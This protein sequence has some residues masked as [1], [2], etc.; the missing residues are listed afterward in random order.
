MKFPLRLPFLFQFSSLCIISVMLLSCHATSTAYNGGS[1][2]FTCIFIHDT[3]TQGV[4]DDSG[5]NPF[6]TIIPSADSLATYSAIA[7][8]VSIDSVLPALCEKGFA[9]KSAYYDL[10]YRCMDAI[11]P[12]VVVVLMSPNS[13][14]LNQGFVFGNNGRFVCAMDLLHYSPGK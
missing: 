5:T 9:I 14:I 4:V 13:G 1:P 12:R 10:E 6:L 8:N 11:G 2:T 3:L 7:S